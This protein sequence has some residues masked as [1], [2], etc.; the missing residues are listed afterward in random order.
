MEI[1]ASDGDMIKIDEKFCILITFEDENTCI[2]DILHEPHKVG[3]DKD[4]IA[5]VKCI[6]R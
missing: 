1:K 4:L 3:E 6:K 2:L 5:I